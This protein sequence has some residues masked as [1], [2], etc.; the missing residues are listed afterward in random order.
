MAGDGWGVPE[1]LQSPLLFLK[2]YGGKK[3][4]AK[5]KKKKA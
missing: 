5:D 4:A 1:V 2:S 3:P